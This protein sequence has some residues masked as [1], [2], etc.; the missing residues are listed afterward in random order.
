VTSLISP[1]IDYLAFERGLAKH[2]RAAYASDLV[3]FTDF[4][5]R[6]HHCLDASAVTTD[7]ILSF[8][9]A[10]KQA[11]MA[12]STL[13]RRLVSIKGFFAY[14]R[15]ENIITVNV[16]HAIG[17]R[18]QG[19]T[20]PHVL[21]QSQ[22]EALLNAPSSTTR[23]GIRDRAILELF[24][25]SGLRVSELAGLPLDGLRFD[26][27]LVRCFGKGSKMRLVP[28]GATAEAALKHYLAASRP[29]YVPCPGEQHVFLNPRGGGLSRVGVWG[30]LKRHA[31][32]AGLGDDVSPHWLR[33]SFATH[34]LGNGAPIRIIQ[35]MLGHANI[36]TT[37]I[38]THVDSA[39]LHDIHERFHPRS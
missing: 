16:A 20:L 7:D 29:K 10:E 9:E 35:E 22:V 14:L 6:R 12:D 13:A 21:S 34:M 15:A 18:R 1:F 3:R 19:R 5:A 28:M 11:G 33:H 36:G 39:R 8:Q 25:A 4:L 30:I 32:Q 23:D 31:R 24:Y 27:A 2:T 38:Y 26:E 17:A 37:Q